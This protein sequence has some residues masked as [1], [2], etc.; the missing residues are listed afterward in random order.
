MLQ[1]G[2]AVLEEDR[3]YLYCFSHILMSTAYVSQRLTEQSSW[4]AEA[5]VSPKYKDHGG[6]LNFLLFG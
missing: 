2:F 5:I 1:A 3:H 4:G 6:C